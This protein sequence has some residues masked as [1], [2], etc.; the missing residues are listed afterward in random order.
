MGIEMLWFCGA[1]RILTLKETDRKRGG[2]AGTDGLR[3]I[4]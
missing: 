1:E 2:S 3:G 4:T